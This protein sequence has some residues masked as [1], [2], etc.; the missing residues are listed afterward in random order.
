MFHNIKGNRKFLLKYF[1]WLKKPWMRNSLNFIFQCRRIKFNHNFKGNKTC[2]CRL[3]GGVFDFVGGK[4]SH[5]LWERQ[6]PA[7]FSLPSNIK[8]ISKSF[9][10][11]KSKYSNSFSV[12][13]KNYSNKI[14]WKM[15]KGKK[16]FCF[17]KLGL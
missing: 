4:K 15:R 14:T 1:Y 17:I 6:L 9:Y 13:K 10:P 5:V 11:V 8:D 12:K 2:K 7:M 16:L 3:F